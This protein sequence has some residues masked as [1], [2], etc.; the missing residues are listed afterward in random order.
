MH[1]KTLDHVLTFLP[2]ELV[3]K[4][5]D[6]EQFKSWA[7][8][9]LRTM[10]F[11]GRFEQD[12]CLLRVENHKV[13]LPSDIR[14]IKAIKYIGDDL[15][16]EALTSLQQCVVQSTEDDP[17]QYVNT[18]ITETTTTTATSTIVEKKT[19]HYSD[20]CSINKSLFVAS[21]FYNQYCMPMKFIGRTGKEYFDKSCYNTIAGARSCGYNEFSIEDGCLITNFKE[22][23]VCLEYQAETKNDK[24]EFMA[25]AEPIHIWRAMAAYIIG[26]YYENQ[27]ILQVQG[28]MAN[29]ERYL[30]RAAL[31]KREALGIIKLKNMRYRALS[32]IMR[33]EV[34]ILQVP[35][36]WTNKINA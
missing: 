1:Y 16:D 26:M 2:V 29:S 9:F 15:P 21:V 6:T 30:R 17:D 23:Y 35:L 27:S 24:G 13:A 7:L 32:D 14:R 5:D 20:Q 36:V 4:V 10:N 25:P 3:N 22:G 18:E 8:Q 31:L 11:E 28:A 33:E 34:R 19:I 12:L